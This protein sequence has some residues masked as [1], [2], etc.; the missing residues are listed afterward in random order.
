LRQIGAARG[1]DPLP[2]LIV[3]QRVQQVLEREMRMAPRR[4][5]PVRH[6]E[7]DFKSLTEQ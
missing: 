4:R 5:F 2:V 6:R 7:H 3:R 1:K